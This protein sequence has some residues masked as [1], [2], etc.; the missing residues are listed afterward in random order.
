MNRKLLFPLLA[1]FL[2]SSL[3]PLSADERLDALSKD[4][5]AWLEE[6]V[7]YII[8]DAERE[9]FLSLKTKEERDL[10]VDAFWERRDPNPATLENEFEVEHYRRLEYANRV[11]GRDS[12]R[13]GWK[14]DRGRYYI[15]LGEPTEIQRYDGLNEIV[16]TELWLYNGD[17][18]A[19]LPAR[20]NLL[21]FQENNIG[22]YKLYHPFADGPQA[23]LNDGFSYR[24]NQNLAIDRLEVVSIDL[25]RASIT[26]DLSE[27]TS[28][29][30]SPRNTRDPLLLQVRPS[31]SVDRNLAEI[32]EYPVKKIDTD[33][34]DGYRRYG[35][36]VS[37]DYSFNYVANR[38]TFAVLMGPDNTPFVHYSIELDPASLS[39]EANDRETE[40]YTTLDV[41]LELRDPEGHL[42]AVTEN[43]P[44]LRLT[45]SQFEQ[46]K[47]YPFA[48]RDSFPVLPGDYQ[49][50]VI[51][52]NRATRQYTVA[53]GELNVPEISS[54]E[55]VLGELLLAAN[56]SDA[57]AS[58]DGQHKTFQLG[59]LEV[60]PVVES[61]F[62]V[63]TTIHAVTQV[64]NARPG[65]RVHFALVKGEETM[66]ES[67]VEV[68]DTAAG[69]V[70]TTFPLLGLEPGD[71]SVVAK[72]LD[73]SEQLLDSRTRQTQL[74]PR[75]SIPRPAFVYR[76]SF[77]SEIPG[78]LDMTLGEQLM[79]R[80]R[81]DEAV[82]RLRTAVDADNPNLD[83]AKW[84][85][86]S[87]LL[88]K[89]EADEA[90]KLLRPLEQGYPDQIEVVEGLG[91]SYWIRKEY[92][93]AVP[94]FEHAKMLRPPDTSLL[95][96]LG[97]CYERL[98]RADEARE[99]FELSLELNPNQDG[100]KA[101]LAGLP[102]A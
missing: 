101:R 52:K 54:D 7:V 85:L 11:L 98:S 34:L 27:P 15:I 74:S 94:Y 64:V 68:A 19:G 55:P 49:V 62:S 102:G 91:F 38:S 78:L 70:T 90:L 42:L 95:N 20:F 72:L 1:T 48:Y 32:D 21:F 39:L 13:P 69:A 41:N 36:R 63:N 30:L 58:E 67:D 46:A 3:V 84:K 65:Q 33:Y 96:A 26:I 59:S 50:S 77:S 100:V 35:N 88:F 61:V 29:I 5:R 25:A 44:F 28:S 37:A 76:H 73:E 24:T 89:R 56:V 53:E 57:L 4:E 79:T 23:L 93:Q 92:G 75:T 22:E 6:E 80:G 18:T 40:F 81:I 87:A 2:L 12:T 14:T 71:Y 51:L 31:M 82:Q 10:F 16:N 45:A 66:H 86:A 43:E 60:D 99:M 17:T 83:M 9:V 8:S 97:D 47:A